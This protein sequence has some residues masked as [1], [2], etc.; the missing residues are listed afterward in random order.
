[1]SK[2]ECMDVCPARDDARFQEFLASCTGFRIALDEDTPRDEATG[3]EVA[4][5]LCGSP[6]GPNANEPSMA[7]E[8]YMNT[9]VPMPELRK[10]YDRGLLPEQG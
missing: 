6:D 8:D 5:P 7:V 2:A 1:M 9:L 3:A 4:R 10:L